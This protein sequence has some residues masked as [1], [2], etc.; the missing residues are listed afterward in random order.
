METDVPV[1]LVGRTAANLL[2][3]EITPVGPEPSTAGVLLIEVELLYVDAVNQR[4]AHDTKLVRALVDRPR[5]D[6]ELADPTQ[7]TY[8]YRITVHRTSGASDVGL[9]TKSSDRILV[10]P[11]TP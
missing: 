1:V 5:W 4:R 3:V 10:V 11:V 7:R 2:A 9:W 6:V 8:E